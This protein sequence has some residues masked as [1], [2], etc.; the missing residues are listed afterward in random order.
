MKLEIG[1]CATRVVAASDDE[2]RW[3]IGYLTFVDESNAFRQQR[4]GR[5]KRVKP[6]RI[7]LYDPLSDTFPSGLL[8][9]VHDRA[10]EQGFSVEW[11]DA[12]QPGLQRDPAA[13]LA[14]LRPYQRDALEAA[15]KGERGLLWLAT[16]GGKTEVAIGLTR[17]LPGKWLFVVHRS[18]IM[19]EVA[20]RYDKRTAEHGLALAPAARF[21][22]GHHDLGD[23]T[24]GTFQTIYAKLAAPEGRALVAGTRGLIVDEAHTLPARTFYGVAMEFVHARHRIGL[25]GTPL[26]REDRRSLMAVGALGPVVYRLRAEALIEAGVL[27]APTVRMV[28]VEQY[29]IRPTYRGVYGEAVVRSKERND[30]LVAIAKFARKPALVF[31]KLTAH[32]MALR[33]LMEKAGLRVA[34]VW[35]NSQQATRSNAIRSLER[36][37]LDVV[38]CSVV[39]QE[40]IDIPALASVIVGAGGKSTIAA[41]QRIGR[42]MRRPD[43]KDGFDVWDINDVGTPVLER[44]SKTRRRAYERE[45]FDVSDHALAQLPL[46]DL[47]KAS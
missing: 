23:F 6:P 20:E 32:G 15:I 11:R 35:G 10:K 47:A 13:D 31:V 18:S 5:A 42:G 16:G 41:L 37:D 21:G 38:I 19:Y 1:N 22:D 29:V 25:S 8:R 46:C 27:A 4:G 2:T 39:W 17:A 33:T 9:L 30:A 43:G 14:W 12:R 36:G 26:D 40:G 45:G 24:V 34:F 3:L 28:P 7:R 44:H